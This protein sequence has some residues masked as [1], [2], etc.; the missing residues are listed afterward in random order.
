MTQKIITIDGP[1]GSGKGTI[2]ALLAKK[3]GWQVLDSGALYRLVGLA[4]R[5]KG[6]DFSDDSA[7]AEVAEKL[8][9][10]FKDGKVFLEKQEVTDSIRSESAGNDASKVAA[11][12]A[13]RDALL[14]WQQQS[15][16]E[17]GLVADGRDMGTVVFPHAPLKFFLTA[18]AE[19]RA[20]RRYKQLKEKGMSANLAHLIEKIR[21]RDER[22]MSRSAAPLRPADDAIDIESSNLTI[23]EVMEKILR[24][25]AEVFKQEQI[26]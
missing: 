19:E 25:V 26:S 11:V 23:D 10:V 6:L 21:E 20:N 22:D 15:A 13:V 24:D 16:S 2:A 8:D 1:S 4:A 9:V 14:R 12:P 3:L 18:S 7:L 17:Q 5:N